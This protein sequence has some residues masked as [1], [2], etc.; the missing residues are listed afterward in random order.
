MTHYIRYSFLVAIAL[1]LITVAVANR[2]PVELKLLPADMADILPIGGSITVPLFFVIFCG[3]LAGLL[4]GFIWEYLREFKIRNSLYKT[5][6]EI[7]A[8]ERELSRLREKTGEGKDD[9]LAI[10][11]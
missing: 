2:Q 4:I 10:L 3:V 5:N 6:K 1:I 7:K 9:I 11:D 8:L